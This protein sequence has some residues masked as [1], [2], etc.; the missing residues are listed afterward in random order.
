M[1]GA[2]FRLR[3]VCVGNAFR[4]AVESC[5]KLTMTNTFNSHCC[6]DSK[7]VAYLGRCIESKNSCAKK[8]HVLGSGRNQLSESAQV[9]ISGRFIASTSGDLRGRLTNNKLVCMR[10]DFKSQEIR[11]FQ[12]FLESSFFDGIFF[13]VQSQ[14]HLKAA[15]V[16]S[17]VG[18]MLFGIINN[19]GC[20]LLRSWGEHENRKKVC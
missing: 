8:N 17:S 11:A 2:Q 9:L 13:C 14:Y 15:G 6:C 3:C 18:A 20:A 1:C 16:M 10:S 7:K 4:R 5:I 19:V 12:L